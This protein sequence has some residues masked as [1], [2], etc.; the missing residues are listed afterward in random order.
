[1]KYRKLT[2]AGDYTFGRGDGNFIQN[3]PETVA[4]AVRTRLNL[5]QGEWMLDITEGTPYDS[6]ILGAGKI[7]T[8]DI[9]IQE[10]ILNT[11]GVSGIV[12]YSSGVDPTTREVTITC[13]IQTVY[14]QTQVTL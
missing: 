1:M 10:V 5:R 2:S 3:T 9:A 4:Q 14:G 6:S 12:D 11:L 8:Y 7:T 13:T